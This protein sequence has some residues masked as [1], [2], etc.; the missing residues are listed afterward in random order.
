M[1]SRAR[2]SHG[3]RPQVHQQPVRVFV[4]R[5]SA[6]QGLGGVVGPCRAG[7]CL[8]L[9]A[10]DTNVAQLASATYWFLASSG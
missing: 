1:P 8:E 2:G 9:G 10:P 4:T 6:L 3:D 5:D 7:A